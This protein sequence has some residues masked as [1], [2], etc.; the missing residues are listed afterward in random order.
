MYRRREGVLANRWELGDW[1]QNRSEFEGCC[2]T[3]SI[4]MEPM[5]GNVT[6]FVQL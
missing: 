2:Q 6:R 4:T 1:H 3:P 5:Q